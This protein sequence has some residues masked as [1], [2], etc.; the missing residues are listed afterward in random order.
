[1]A[2]VA[3]SAG[4]CIVYCKFN[5]DA[6]DSTPNGNDG[7]NNGATFSSSGGVYAGRVT[8]DGSNDHISYGTSLL[9][10][11][12]AF[13]V[14]VWIKYA[15]VPSVDP[16]ALDRA[17]ILRKWS[18]GKQSMLF[19]VD[20]DDEIQIGVSGNP[21]NSSAVLSTGV[22]QHVVMIFSGGSYQDAYLDN[23]RV[24]ND[25]TSIPASVTSTIEELCLGCKADDGVYNEYFKGDM[26]ELAIFDVALSADNVEFLY[27]SGSPGEAQQYPF[28]TNSIT[29]SSPNGGES[30]KVGDS[31]TITWSSSGS[32]GSLTIELSTDNGSNYS[33]IASGESDDGSYSWT[34]PDNKSTQCL[35]RIG[36]G[37]VSDTSNAVFSIIGPADKPA[38]GG[39]LIQSWLN[40]VVNW[41]ERG[42]DIV[43]QSN[44]MILNYVHSDHLQITGDF[45]AKVVKVSDGDT[46]TLRTSFRDFDF[47]MRLANIDA[48]E[49]NDGGQFAKD[50]L[51]SRVLGKDVVVRIDSR[52]RVG[53]YG[54]LIGELFV[55]GQNLGDEM[56]R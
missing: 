8:F 26:A 28:T 43:E 50:Y 22:W 39:S 18:T 27:N 7:T 25:T 12:T 48:N 19:N 41:F 14:S 49:M 37:S 9:N 34:I 11:E 54:R 17:T 16:G 46:V 15:S 24:I 13:S 3:P 35:I 31:E 53:K 6:S 36:D 38:G 1:M 10:S 23:V 55:D 42:K 4:D 44:D 47:P 40:P 56:V 20:N 29:L 52:N 5:S 51:T 45:S 21:A 33:T 2:A 30:W 32:V